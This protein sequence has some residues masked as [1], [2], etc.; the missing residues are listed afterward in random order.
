MREEKI[1]VPRMT[2][3]RDQIR[4]RRAG[5]EVLLRFVAIGLLSLLASCGPPNPPNERL[6]DQ[7]LMHVTTSPIPGAQAQVLPVPPG[8]ATTGAPANFCVTDAGYCPLAAA[9]P[10]GQNCLC[11]AGS[12]AYGGQTAAAPQAVKYAPPIKFLGTQ[13]PYP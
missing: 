3:V 7:Q 9:T 12:L 11:K 1:L 2:Q 8:T 4:R 5:D 13:A 6:L 10:A